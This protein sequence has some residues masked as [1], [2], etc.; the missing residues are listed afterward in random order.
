M[1]NPQMMH[2]TT[3]HNI[4]TE[5]CDFDTMFKT[6]EDFNAFRQIM[7]QECYMKNECT[8]DPLSMSLKTFKEDTL[9]VVAEDIY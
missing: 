9:E 1:V 2:P 7:I 3:E 4:D 8:I 6:E 5:S